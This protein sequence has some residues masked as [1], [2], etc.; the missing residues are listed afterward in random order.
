MV[1]V[2]A[3]HYLAAEEAGPDA[4]DAAEIRGKAQAMLVRAGE[5][6]ESL[7]AAAEARRYFEQAAELT[8][9]PSERA[10]LLDKAGEMAATSG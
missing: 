5:R 10:A 9:D 1:E 2:I 7:A 3:S 6:A 4:E 8:E